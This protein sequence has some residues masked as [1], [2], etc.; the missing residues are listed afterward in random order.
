L[1]VFNGTLYFADQWDDIVQSVLLSTD[2]LSNFCLNTLAKFT[3]DGGPCLKAS[4]FNPLA[5]AIDPLGDVFISGGNDNL[6]QRASAATGIFS[7][8]AGAPSRS[9]QAAFSG[10]GGPAL[11]ARMANLGTWVDGNDNLYIADGG[12]NRIRYVP[13]APAV[14]LGATNLSTGQWPLGVAGNPVPLTVT[15]AGGADTTF[16]A[17][18]FTGTN[19][20][21]FSQTNNCT[22]LSPQAT[23][24]VQVTL[25]PSVYG[26]ESATLN[27]NDNGTGSPQTVTLTGFGPDFAIA[28]SPATMTVAPGSAGTSTV[29]LTPQA[30]FAQAIGLS[31]PTGLPTGATCSFN[32][33]SVQLYGGSA[34]QSTLTIQTSSSTPA[35][36][37][38]V[39]TTG[40]YS[41]LSHS[42]T[43]ALTVQ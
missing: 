34:Q 11:N 18:T 25:T 19:A 43:I 20:G 32:P 15:G 33:S 5:L 36:T 35:G 24:T 3:G 40:V 7:T 9:Y 37:Y 10:D 42:A 23:C 8:V 4:M 38:T 16:S 29:T 31:C 26:A 28:D 30:K 1:G 39:T 14:S 6:V 27:L 12:N 41:P 17:P 21:D 22:L 13:L 2:I